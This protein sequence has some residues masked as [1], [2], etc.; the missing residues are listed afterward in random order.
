MTV[1]EQNMACAMLNQSLLGIISPNF[2]RVAVS[3]SDDGWKI[4]FWL[5]RDDEVDREEIEDSMG[6]FDGLVL[7][8]DSP[9]SDIEAITEICS[10]SLPAL[11]PSNWRVV[12]L[13]R[14]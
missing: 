6:D 1:N 4:R 5:E 14:E 9:P 13:R 11:D 3:F 8:M 10:A 12:F 7:G 2:R